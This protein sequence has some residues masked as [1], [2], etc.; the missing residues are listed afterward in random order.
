MIDPHDP[1]A[2]WAFGNGAEFPGATGELSTDAGATVE[3]H[4][5]MRLRGDF[6]KGG[7]YVQ[8]GRKIDKIDIRELSMWIRS[9]E[10]DHFTLRIN[11]ASG[12]THQISI[13][14]EPKP[15][16]QR[17]VLP[18]QRFFA[19]RGDAD[20]VTSIAKYE[21]WGGAKDG[22]WHGPATA[23]YILA[24]R[25]DSQKTPTLWFGS[26]DIV[27]PPVEVAGAEVT[28]V[29]ALSEILEG[30]HDWRFSRGEEFPGAK[31]S[32][33]VVADEGVRQKSAL[34]LAGDFSGGGAYVAAIKDLPDLEAKDVPA[35]HLREK[36]ENAASITVTLVDVTG[37]THQRKGVQI[38]HDGQWHDFTIQ[39]QEIAGGEHWGGAKDGKWH[40]PL[41]QLALSLTAD[42]DAQNKQPVLYLADMRADALMA[43]YAH[44]A[45][46]QAGFDE[47]RLPGGWSA[48]DGVSIDSKVTSKGAGS[49][50]LSRSVDDAAKPCSATSA[51]FPAAPGQWQIS[52]EAKADLQSPDN[53][54][55]GAILLEALDVSGKVLDHFTIAEVYGQHPW[56]SIQKRLLLPNETASARFQIKLEK[57]WGS[58][59]IDE[60]S[61]SYLSPAPRRDDRISRILFSTAQLGNLLFPQDS[62]KVTVT[63]EARKPLRDDQHTLTY[64]VRDYWGAEQTKP[65][66]VTLGHSEKKGDKLSYDATLDLS[67]VPLEIGRYYEVHAEIPQEGEE[68]FRNYT[69]LAILPEAEA[70][71]YPPDDIPFTSR[72][73][74]NRFS[75]YVKLT[76]RL[77]IRI[78]GL[79]GGWSS[80]PPYKPEAP[81]LDLCAKL[82]MGWLTNTPIAGIETGKTEYDE[83]ALRQGVRNLIEQYGKVRPMI[84]NLGNEPHGTGTRVLANVAAYRAVYEE[85]KKVD[86]SIPVVATSVEPNEE[87]FKAGY[88]QWCDAYDF[89]I[90]E[91]SEDVRRTMQQYH[92]LMQKYGV[93]KPLWSTE[94]GLNSQGLTRRIVA[95]E[96]IK[97]FATFFACGGAKVSWFGL[98]YPDPEGKDHGSAGD[99]HNVFDCRYNRYCPRLDAIAY[100]NGVNAI[101]IKK[102]VVERIY[103]D[104]VHAV[105]FR[106]KDQR[107]LQVLWKDHGRV[108]AAVPLRGVGAVRAIH[109]DGSRRDLDAGG[110]AITLTIDEDPLLLLYA[111]GEA[112]LP[113]K[114]GTP[115]ASM[116]NQPTGVARGATTS[117]SLVLHG[118]SSHDIEVVI[119]PFWTQSKSE[120][121]E[122]GKGT[123]KIGFVPAPESAVREA[124]VTLRLR[125]SEGRVCG[126]LVFHAPVL[127]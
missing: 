76:D 17:L 24:G 82:G 18:L 122:G 9:P 74:D 41:R 6:T 31:G 106:D 114:L 3:G 53:S 94:L 115:L 116:E 75:E 98:L 97:K 127:N 110:K 7:N 33:S 124:D 65:V 45:A 108:D 85:V 23:I 66:Q 37:Q 84:I 118:I 60:L 120:P 55:H 104:G 99:S 67:A 62:R 46:F 43:V 52:L 113:E 51:T 28:R 59:H 101:S 44:P 54:Y 87:Y 38:P 19:H 34:K 107:C 64:V 56:E 109:L 40:G 2:G 117:L 119:P 91:H 93:V 77:G 35:I 21:S 90:Y 63:V 12:Q 111:G 49:L 70:R 83:T 20:A 86:P 80:K 96:V 58:L 13:K 123:L 95:A 72:N 48:T 11:D 92:D 14:L 15:D 73:W 30:Q 112:A 32:L 4:P 39:P 125:D 8:A 121:A 57:C 79:W 29:V 27:S 47:A 26:L 22:A 61:A 10:T 103:P 78:C 42:S 68:P 5:S 100:Y 36:S 50:Q 1:A 102:F 105:L 126:E 16:W 71:Q 25:S 89:H 69:S 81:S 88:G